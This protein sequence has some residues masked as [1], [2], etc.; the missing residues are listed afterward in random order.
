MVRIALLANVGKHIDDF[1]LEIIDRW[2]GMG[3]EVVSA[4][5]TSSRA[6]SHTVLRKV[7]RRP[8]LKNFGAP[9]ELDR[10][11]RQTGSDVLLTNTAVPSFLARTRIHSYPV[12]YFCHGLHWN[13]GTALAERVWQSLERVALR[14]TSGVVVM[15]DDDEQ[16]FERYAPDV[17]RMRLPYGVGLDTSRYRPQSILSTEGGIRLIWAGE[18]SSRKRPELA[19]DVLAFLRGMGI[20]AR[21]QMCGTGKRLEEV[22]ADV[23]RRQL[24]RCVTFPGHVSD[25]ST[26]LADSHLMLLTSQWEGLPRV[27]LEAIAVGRAVFAFDVK[28]TRSLP[29]VVVVPGDDPYVLAERIAAS[30]ERGVFETSN[31]ADELDVNWV[32]EKLADF[33][34]GVV[35][36]GPHGRGLA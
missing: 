23:V 35:N 7:S 32:A 17:P 36:C 21:L 4:A 12:I 30:L 22:K 31:Q 6:S 8:R 9:R 33:A 2:R 29:G 20:D 28:G 15:N 16:W 24:T 3:H 27:G 18:F 5:S 34:T 1:D 26:R 11:M 19:I 10:W 25:I 13:K 14:T